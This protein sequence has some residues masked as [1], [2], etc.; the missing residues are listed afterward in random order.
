MPGTW[1]ESICSLCERQAWCV[2]SFL[3]IPAPVIGASKHN[4]QYTYLG[5]EKDNEAGGR[6]SE[7]CGGDTA[8]RVR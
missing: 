6:L 5:A 2:G 3:S 7:E 4:F 1:L 8:T